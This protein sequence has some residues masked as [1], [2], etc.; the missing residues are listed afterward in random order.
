ML[1]VHDNDP[2]NH[3]NLNAQETDMNK[4]FFLVDLWLAHEV[5]H[6]IVIITR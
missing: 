3:I 2:F 4:Y 1:R 6:S 5:N